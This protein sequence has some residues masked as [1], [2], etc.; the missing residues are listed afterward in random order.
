MG[1]IIIAT[2]EKAKIIVFHFSEYIYL[3][4]F[5]EGSVEMPH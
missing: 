4:I 2:Y 5:P 3:T 1:K